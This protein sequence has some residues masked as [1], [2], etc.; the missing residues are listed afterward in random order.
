MPEIV[1]I[2]QPSHFYWPD[3]RPCYEVEMATKPGQMRATTLADARKLGLV[4][5]VTTILSLLSK[6]F[7]DAWKLE[8]AIMAAL[9]LPEIPGESIDDRARRIARDA[10]QQAD[11][12][13]K[14]GS[15]M[16]DAVENYCIR[17]EIP[18]DPTI[19]PLFLPFKEWF[20]QNC[21]RLHYCEKPVVNKVLGYAGKLDCKAHIKGVGVAIIDFKT[22]KPNSKG[23]HSVYDTDVM[24]LAAYRAADAMQNPIPATACL[25]VIINSQEPGIHVHQW[26]EAELE[27][28]WRKFEL[29]VHY[30]QLDKNYKPI[31]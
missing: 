14:K 3:G 16:H 6:P 9:T 27:A 31:L 5:S 25:S 30:W 12:A 23:K 4:P 11:D 8:Q 28:A 10:E 7:L 17:G 29:L 24:Q 19:R 18:L 13:R 22:R 1:S 21:E 20:A 15:L 2:S 26:P